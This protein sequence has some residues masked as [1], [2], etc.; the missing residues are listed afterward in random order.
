[1]EE[2]EELAGMAG[3]ER[4]EVQVGEPEEWAWATELATE[5]ATEWVT[6]PGGLDCRNRSWRSRQ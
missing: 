4:M 2:L 5:W 6:E 3:M 1:L